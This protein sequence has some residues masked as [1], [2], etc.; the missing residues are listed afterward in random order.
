LK[1]ICLPRVSGP[2]S[3]RAGIFLLVILGLSIIFL[4]PPLTILSVKG[5]PAE[6]ELAAIPV[7]PGS[8]ME[9]EYIHSMYGVRQIEVFSI[10]PEPAFHLEKVL[11]G[12]LAAAL[13]YDPEPSSGLTFQDEYWVIKGDG[14]NYPSLRYRVGAATYHML[15][16]KDRRID[17]SGPSVGTEGLI[18][19]EF[20]KRSRLDSFFIMAKRKRSDILGG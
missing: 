13:Y 20:E 7:E 19:I 4:T 16:I 1:R 15:R 14:K 2:G 12:S 17:L 11:F 5:G 10:G 6:H 9:I 3:K 8:R 18:R